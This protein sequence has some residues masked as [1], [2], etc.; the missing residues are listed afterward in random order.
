MLVFRSSPGISWPLLFKG[1]FDRVMAAV[2]IV[3]LSWLWLVIALLIKLTSSGP[4]FF[5]ILG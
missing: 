1:V 5:R 3:V 4:V 2:L